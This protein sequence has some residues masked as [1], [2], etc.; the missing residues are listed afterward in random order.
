M[1]PQL[2]LV[3]VVINLSVFIIY[4]VVIIIFSI[5]FIFMLLVSYYSIRLFAEL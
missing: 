5:L 4:F 2:F 1:L 3:L